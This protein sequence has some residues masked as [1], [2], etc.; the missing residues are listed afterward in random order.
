[1]CVCVCVWVCACVNGAVFVQSIS[2]RK[3]AGSNPVECS[4][5]RPSCTPL[6]VGGYLQPYVYVRV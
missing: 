2:N 3:T 1:M 4:Y 5:T 6:S